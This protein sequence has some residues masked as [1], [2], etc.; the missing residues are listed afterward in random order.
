MG[1]CGSVSVLEHLIDGFFDGEFVDKFSDRPG[2]HLVMNGVS[3][4]AESVFVNKVVVMNPGFKGGHD[5][6]ICES[7]GFSDI[8]DS[9]F[10]GYPESKLFGFEFMNGTIS[11]G[12]DFVIHFIS[13]SG[14]VRILS[15]SVLA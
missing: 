6:G 5:R 4:E 7:V 15:A 12:S 2:F 13:W 10:P 14:G 3:E 11:K 9:S 1:F 8:R